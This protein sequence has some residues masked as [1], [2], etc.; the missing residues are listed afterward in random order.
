MKEIPILFSAEM[1]TS[2]LQKRKFMTRRIIKE[3]QD[4]RVGGVAFGCRPEIHLIFRNNKEQLVKCPFQ[5]GDRMWVRETHA[6]TWNVH[7][8]ITVQ[9]GDGSERR[10]QL[11]ELSVG[12]RKKLKARKSL[13]KGWVSARFLPKEFARIWLEIPT[14]PIDEERDGNV[15]PEMLQAIDEGDAIQEG[16]RCMYHDGMP[17]ARRSYY[18]YPCN[19]ARDD[20]YIPDVKPLHGVLQARSAA[21]LSFSSLWASIHGWDSWNENPWVWVICFKV[22]STTGKPEAVQYEVAS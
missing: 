17:D 3:V 9:Y 1:V 15:Y 8:L 16:I 5:P 2:I 21:Q 6:V 12:L 18:F 20:S 14:T 22:L 4:K 13:N 19:D 7:D 10:W 11:N